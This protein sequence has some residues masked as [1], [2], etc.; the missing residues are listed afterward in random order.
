[1]KPLVTKISVGSTISM[2]RK[3]SN[4]T[5][6]VDRAVAVVLTSRTWTLMTSSTNSLG[7]VE[8]EAAVDL[9]AVTSTST[10]VVVEAANTSISSSRSQSRFLT[11]SRTQMLCSSTSAKYS[12]STVGRKFGSYTSLTPSLR[13]ARSSRRNTSLFLSAFMAW[14]KSVRSTVCKKKS[15]VKNSASIKCLKSSSSQKISL[16][17]AISTRVRWKQTISWMQLLKRCKTSS[18]SLL[19]PTLIPS[20]SV[21]ELQ[22]IKSFYLQ[23]KSRHRLSIKLYQRST[24]SA[25][26]LVKSNRVKKI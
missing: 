20:S 5:K 10:S 13:N 2:V 26:I 17:M 15:F 11:F 16:M 24:W 22:S 3:V 14:S 9:V 7:V 23:R 25:L 21:I 6:Q 4:S 1:M 8:V 18:M 19:P 12:S